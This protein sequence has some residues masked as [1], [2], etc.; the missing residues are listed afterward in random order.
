VNEEAKQ[1]VIAAGSTVR[2]LTAEQRAKWVAVMKPVW[3][4]FEGD[5][6][7]DLMAGAQAANA[8]N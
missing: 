7:A 8:T 1:A 2:T 3:S 4:K 5:I 6:G